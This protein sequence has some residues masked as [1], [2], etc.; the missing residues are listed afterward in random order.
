MGAE[1]DSHKLMVQFIAAYGAEIDFSFFFGGHK[2][3]QY[4]MLYVICTIS[5]SQWTRC[6]KRQNINRKH[7]FI[8]PM[9]PVEWSNHTF[10]KGLITPWM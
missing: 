5:L 1:C 8:G 7:P 10:L 4:H 9:H 2:D 3:I 6:T